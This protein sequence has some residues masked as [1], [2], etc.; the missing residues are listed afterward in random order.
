MIHTSILPIRGINTDLNFVTEQFYRVC[1]EDE[2][3]I[4]H[5]IDGFIWR[6]KMRHHSARSIVVRVNSPTQMDFAEKWLKNG[7]D[8]VSNNISYLF[9]YRSDLEGVPAVIG[10]ARDCNGDLQDVISFVLNEDKTLPLIFNPTE[11]NWQFPQNLSGKKETY[12]FRDY[13]ENSKLSAK[14]VSNV[15]NIPVNLVRKF[16]EF[17]E[18][19]RTGKLDDY[20]EKKLLMNIRNTASFFK[21]LDESGDLEYKVMNNQSLKYLEFQMLFKVTRQKLNNWIEKGIVESYSLGRVTKIKNKYC[22]YLLENGEKALLELHK[23]KI[24]GASI[25]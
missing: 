21:H 24:N 14:E 3:S 4:L 18:I 8:D 10:A 19:E 20:Y 17:N 1:S 15:F 5:L 6:T 2:R 23:K 13:N 12:N 7:W 25:G 16:C 9:V 22:R 11:I